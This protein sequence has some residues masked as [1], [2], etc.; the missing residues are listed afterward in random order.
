MN[1]SELKEYFPYIRSRDEI[2][3][4][5]KNNAGLSSIFYSWNEQ[6]QNEFISF[7][8]GACGVKIMYDSFF[9]EVMNAESNP[10]PLE[11]FLTT[12]LGRKV[13]ILH[14]LPNDTTRI[15]DEA[16]LLVTDII[17]QLEDGS[18]ANI[19]VQ[20]IGYMFPAQRCSCYSA[21]MLLR[22]YKRIRSE[23]KRDFTYRDVKTVYLI[24]LYERSPH[25]LSGR[26][27]CYIHYG[28]T[29]FNTGISLD[30]LQDFILISLD[31]FHKHMHN[32]P[33]E[34]IEEAWLTF[35]SDDSPERIIEIIT[36]YP[37]FKPLYD[38]IYRMCTDVGKVMTMFSE[39][40]R[41]LDRNTTKLMIDTMT[42]E[43]EDAKAELEA[44]RA[45]LDGTR[46]ALSEVKERLNLFNA[47]LDEANSQLNDAHSQLDEANSQLNDAH[48]QLDEANS[49]LN[50]K[51]AVIA[52]LR[53]QLAEAL[54]HNS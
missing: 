40:L 24:V 13:H 45:E 7:C 10:E 6:E 18:V 46:A 52:Q 8:S 32:K 4:E 19:E 5:I 37:D 31:N 15:T 16:S 50:E 36:K 12:I 27:E 47:Q 29:S 21:D 44:S 48:S 38:I 42:K 3:D 1:K 26:P 43:A 34:T 49:Q 20:R 23:K 35:L 22:Q 54:A 2:M 41:I 28:R 14:V 39:E 51:D 17:V 25:E 33:I 11:G 30:M 53:A 9:K